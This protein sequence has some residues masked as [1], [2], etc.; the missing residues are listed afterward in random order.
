MKLS[1]HFYY[2]FQITHAIRWAMNPGGLSEIITTHGIYLSSF[3]PIDLLKNLSKTDRVILQTAP[4]DHI[5]CVWILNDSFQTY[6]VDEYHT[7]I[8]FENGTSLSI[9]EPK[10]YLDHKS[11]RLHT[12]KFN[13]CQLNYIFPCIKEFNQQ[14]YSN[15]Y[16]RH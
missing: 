11:K 4:S 14:Y 5:D 9:P 6:K 15:D 7:A 13:E 8:V 10:A 2:I 12:F 16:E 1:I 3:S